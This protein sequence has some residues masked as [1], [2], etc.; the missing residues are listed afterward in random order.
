MYPTV[1]HTRRQANRHEIIRCEA[2]LTS[3]VIW[4][5][6]VGVLA[7]VTN[8]D[9]PLRGN[10][11]ALIAVAANRQLCLHRLLVHEHGQLSVANS[12]LASLLPWRTSS[13]H[14]RVGESD[15]VPFGNQG[16]L[17][18]M[19]RVRRLE[20]HPHTSC[21]SSLEES[22]ETTET[23]S[24]IE[25]RFMP[26]QAHGKGPVSLLRRSRRHRKEESSLAFGSGAVEKAH[27]DF[28]I[29]GLS[30]HAD[31]TN[32][33][34]TS[35]YLTRHAARK[36][37]PGTAALVATTVVCA[38]NKPRVRDIVTWALPQSSETSQSAL[39]RLCHTEHLLVLTVFLL[40]GSQCLGNCH[41]LRLGMG[42][43]RRKPHEH[44]CQDLPGHEKRA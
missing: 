44:R 18:R 30:S 8:L 3:L 11:V 28:F 10:L 22:N 29:C 41:Q 7:A 26:F 4:I 19:G 5:F 20:G 16:H 36:L 14:W 13:S 17:G 33:F 9:S 40:V 2:P 21:L 31:V 35:T 27:I 12:S 23:P 42:Q 37:Q 25:P 1:S 34:T 15:Q 38:Y 24:A 6:R 43:E 39:L 32:N